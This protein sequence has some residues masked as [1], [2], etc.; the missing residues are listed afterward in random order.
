MSRSVEVKRPSFPTAT[1]GVALKEE[2]QKIWQPLCGDSDHWRAGI[3]SP[4][5]SNL[6]QIQELEKHSC[7]ELFLLIEGE[8]TLALVEDGKL[9]EL[10]L[11][12]EKPVFVDTW[13]SGY[14]PN[15][16]H[17]GRAFIVERDEFI[18]EYKT[19]KELTN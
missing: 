3:Y 17:S 12:K 9:K 7:P 4:S 11:E 6:N 10:K 15:G 13:H 8:L 14:C 18:T 1:K 16:P 5:T 2:P 19:V